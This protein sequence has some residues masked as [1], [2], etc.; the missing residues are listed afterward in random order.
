MNPQRLV[1]AR[2]EKGLSQREV[3]EALGITSKDNAA[4]IKISRYERGIQTPPYDVAC[5]IAEILNVP[6]CYFYIDDKDFAKQVLILYKNNFE[7]G[8]ENELINILKTENK[9]YKQTLKDFKEKLNSLS[10]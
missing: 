1:E 6:T 2:Q 7:N 3:G 10:L 4:R 8:F 9:E 5:R